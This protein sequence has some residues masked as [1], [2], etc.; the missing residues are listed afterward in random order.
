MTEYCDSHRLP[1]GWE[2]R[3]PPRRSSKRRYV[4]IRWV[5]ECSHT[6]SEGWPR[7]SQDQDIPRRPESFTS[8][9]RLHPFKSESEFKILFDSSTSQASNSCLRSQSRFVRQQLKYLIITSD[10]IQLPGVGCTNRISVGINDHID[11]RS[12]YNKW[13]H[14]LGLYRSE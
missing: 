12:K 1:M 6:L 2:L 9:Y 13:E 10:T 8:S 4:C 3:N 14:S 11:W 5:L 7:R